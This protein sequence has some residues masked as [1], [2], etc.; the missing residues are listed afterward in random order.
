[1][2][3]KNLFVLMFI[4]TC[5]FSSCSGED[6][7]GYSRLE[8]Q[9]N[10]VEIKVYSNVKGVPVSI[11]G[12][13]AASNPLI[14]RDYWEGSYTTKMWRFNTIIRCDDE[15]VLLTSEI[16]VNGDLVQKNYANSYLKMGYTLK[17]P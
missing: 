11:T 15:T 13:S 3:I 10:F 4:I 14:I 16:Y 2:K 6:D 17:G 7:G 12:V 8:N 1:M 5:V 9:E